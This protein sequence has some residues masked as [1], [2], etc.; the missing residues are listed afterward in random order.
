MM[1][2]NALTKAAYTTTFCLDE[3]GSSQF[4]Q[5]DLVDDYA[6]KSIQIVTFDSDWFAN[7]LMTVGYENFDIVTVGDLKDKCLENWKLT[8]V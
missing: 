1:R 5:V 2:S 8:F 7:S 6:I 3:F 4:A